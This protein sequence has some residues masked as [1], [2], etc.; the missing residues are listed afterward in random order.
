MRRVKPDT[1]ARAIAA[2]RDLKAA[3]ARAPALDS[4]FSALPPSHKRGYI[5]WIA[6]A[7]RPE[8]RAARVEKTL[9]ML[10]EKR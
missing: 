7:R 9:A 3:L 6:E 10:K 1:I 8:T 4:L 5:D 2:P